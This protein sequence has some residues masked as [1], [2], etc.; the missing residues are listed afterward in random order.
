[1]T[2]EHKTSD[3]ISQRDHQLHCMEIWKGNRFVEQNV[4]SAGI[5]AWVFSHPFQGNQQGGD[6][7]YLSLCVGGIVTR[8]IVADIAGHGDR[9]AKTSKVLLNL[10]R[11]FMNTK[12]QDRLVA[13][14]NRHFTETDDKDGFATAIVAT[15]LS[16]KST[17]LLTN[18][19]HPRPLIYRKTRG[20]WEFLDLPTTDKGLGDNFPFGLDEAT[21]Y[22]HF[23]L[24]I[25]SGDWLLLY[26]DA[27]TESSDEAG[28][29]IGENGLLNIV[30]QIPV[31]LPVSQFGRELNRLLGG[32]CE[33]WLNEDDTTLIAIQFTE[34]RRSP[35]VYEKLIGYWRVVQRAIMF[36]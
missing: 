29:L 9:V 34:G 20:Y 3:T 27:Y 28:N 21:R 13:E 1:M 30:E 7:H 25:E 16:H 24:K 22:E 14:L 36:R 33:Q 26:T 2:T 19:G 11:K 5:Q 8:I 4:N 10:L 35:S 6:I 17:L 23:V 18:A 32:R 15:Y 31:S 12:K